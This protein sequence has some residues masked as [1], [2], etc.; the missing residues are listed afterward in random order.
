MKLSKL[1]FAGLLLVGSLPAYAGFDEGKAAF[2][3]EDYA[4]ALD[5][6]RPLAKHGDALHNFSLVNCTRMALVSS[7]MIL[8][9]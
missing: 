7:K 2:D 6:W 3:K 4:T 9:L 8:K 1:L 5:E